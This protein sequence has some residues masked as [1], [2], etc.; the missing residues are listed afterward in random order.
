MRRV[1]DVDDLCVASVFLNV[2]GC[3]ASVIETNELII[4]Y[5]AC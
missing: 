5:E 2:D 4:K 1:D 3:P